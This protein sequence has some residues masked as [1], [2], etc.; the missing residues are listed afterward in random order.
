MKKKRCF[1]TEEKLLMS[2]SC[3]S[4]LKA[5]FSLCNPLIRISP[6]PFSKTKTI[7]FAAAT[8]ENERCWDT[9]SISV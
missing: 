6:S 7:G 3:N 4:T 5:E 1:I 2:F 8:N 9:E